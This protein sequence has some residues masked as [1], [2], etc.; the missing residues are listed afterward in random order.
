MA[1]IALSN[2]YKPTAVKYRKLGDSI[3]FLSVALQPMTQ[4][5]PLTDHQ[6]LWVNFGIGGLGVIGKFITNLFDGYEEEMRAQGE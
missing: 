1:K 2:F 3:L 5:L 6:R 4:T